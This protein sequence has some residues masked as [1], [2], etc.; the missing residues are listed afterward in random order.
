MAEVDQHQQPL[1][2]AVDRAEKA[3]TFA[4]DA[5]WALEKAQTA[6]DPQGIQSAHGR[7]LQAEKEVEDATEQLRHHDT[8]SH[9][10][11]LLQTLTQLRQASQN[12]DIATEAYQTPK[13][14]R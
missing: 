9:H 5:R 1:M 11:Q 4:Q 14:V 3:I 7:L 12:I 13:Q 6:A 10:Q 8:E 2:H